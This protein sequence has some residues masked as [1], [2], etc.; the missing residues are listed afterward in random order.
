MFVGLPLLLASKRFFLRAGDEG[1]Y[2]V[3][4]A[5]HPFAKGESTPAPRDHHP[6]SPCPF[7]PVNL[8]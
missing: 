2:P 3:L 5:V 7:L 1:V 4:T 6:M 8:T